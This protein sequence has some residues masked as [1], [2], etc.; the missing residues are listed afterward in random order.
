MKRGQKTGA[1]VNRIGEREVGS[2]QGGDASGCRVPPRVRRRR[3]GLPRC[4]APSVCHEPTEVAAQLRLGSPAGSRRSTRSQR[5]TW[6]GPPQRGHR[7]LIRTGC[8]GRLRGRGGRRRRTVRFG[9]TL[10]PIRPAAPAARR[11]GARKPRRGRRAI[12]EAPNPTRARAARTPAAL[13]P[14]R[15]SERRACPGSCATV[16]R[17]SPDGRSRL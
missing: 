4:T 8:S 11:R 15:R 9:R 3:S 7:K 17:A 6:C 5:S 14:R 2:D 13:R 10:V 12:V 1:V 16:R